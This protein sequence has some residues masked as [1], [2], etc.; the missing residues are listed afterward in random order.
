MPAG[1]IDHVNIIA[2]PG[3]VRGRIVVAEHREFGQLADQ[4]LGDIGR[5]VVGQTGRILADQ[6]A[7]MGAHRVEIAQQGDLEGRLGLVEIT[8]NLLD[9]QL[10]PA[11]RVGAGQR[12][13]LGDRHLGGISVDGGRR[14]ENQSP[15][16]EFEHHLAQGQ[17]AGQVVLVV[18]Q[19]LFHRFADRLEPGKMDDAVDRLGAVGQDPPDSVTIAQ[20]DHGQP[21]RLPRQPLDAP[22]R[23]FFGVDQAVDHRHPIAGR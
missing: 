16:P 12:K 18:E 10:G 19:R 8:Q 2:H 7:V 9:H 3:A 5:Q 6:A 22:D 21:D 14:A 11:V 15:D 4:H 17:G 1:Q 13:V 20:V 23:L